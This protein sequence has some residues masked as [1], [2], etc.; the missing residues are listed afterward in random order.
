MKVWR[1]QH[2]ETGIGPY[3]SGLLDHAHSKRRESV[4]DVT[5]A[6]AVLKN[7]GLCGF[8][9]GRQMRKWF[10]PKALQTMKDANFRIAIYEVQ[11]LAFG[12]KQV[13]F[14]P[15]WATL[16]NTIDIEV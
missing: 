11:P 14:D 15:K 3:M 5:N 9:G 2:A 13:V 4:W 8:R 10:G 16:I 7:G 12:R 6:L 1:V